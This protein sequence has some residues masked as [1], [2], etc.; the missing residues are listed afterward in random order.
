MEH[1]Y[2]KSKVKH[3]NEGVYLNY[4][5]EKI[6]DS[7]ILSYT[8][9]RKDIEYTDPE[10]REQFFATEH[11][12]GN[13]V[14]LYRDDNSTFNADDFESKKRK[15]FENV[16]VSMFKSRHLIHTISIFASSKWEGEDIAKNKKNEISKFNEQ[17][18]KYL[19]N[20]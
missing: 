20:E 13:L 15:F 11:S 12:I 17:F 18:N 19:I 14:L 3:E 16:G 9:D 10:T 4:A 8:L 6:E 7:S 1:I 2:P 5:D